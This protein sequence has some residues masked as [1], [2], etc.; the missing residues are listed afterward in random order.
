MRRLQQD[1]DRRIQHQSRD[2]TMLENN[3][4]W[5]TLILVRKRRF[6][7]RDDHTSR[8]TLDRV[9]GKAGGGYS[10]RRSSGYRLV[11]HATWIRAADYVLRRNPHRLRLCLRSLL[12]HLGNRYHAQAL[13]QMHDLALECDRLRHLQRLPRRAGQQA[14]RPPLRIR[15]N[16]MFEEEIQKRRTTVHD[17]PTRSPMVA[18]VAWSRPK[19]A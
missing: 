12:A 13:R 19:R 15:R 9:V 8:S 3:A 5:A 1:Q 6:Q 7:Q 16:V 17:R 2:R 14:P 10:S 4:R 11:L 18:N